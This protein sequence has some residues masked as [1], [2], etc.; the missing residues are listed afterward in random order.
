MPNHLLSDAPVEEF[1]QNRA[2]AENITPAVA[3]LL[4]N[5]ELNQQVRVS[6]ESLLP[7]LKRNAN[8]RATD[9]I[10]TELQR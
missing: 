9:A 3:K 2:N 8:K 6:L 7:S 4:T 10:I 1:I 5:T